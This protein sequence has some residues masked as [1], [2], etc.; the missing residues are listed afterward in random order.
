MRTP[1]SKWRRPDKMA[2]AVRVILVQSMTTTT[3]APRMR[4]N[5]AVE[6]LPDRSRPSNRPRLPSMTA[7]SK[8]PGRES[9][10]K[11]HGAS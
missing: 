10:E 5:S 3:G 9:R 7:M 4:A 6:Q 11:P 2:A 1:C 8:G